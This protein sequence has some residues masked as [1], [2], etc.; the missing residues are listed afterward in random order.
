VAALHASSFTFHVS[1]FLLPPSSFSSVMFGFKEWALICEALGRG[2]QS[3]ILRKGGIA[4]GRAGFRFAHSEFWL[5][6]TLF[7]EQTAKLKVPA[8][9]LLPASREDRMIEV[10]YAARVEW[11]AELADWDKVQALAPFHLWQEAEIEK[12]FQQDAELKVSLAF[13]RVLR[14]REPFVFP[15]L[16]RYGGCRSWVELP[17]TPA[18]LQLDAVLDDPTHR[19]R[20][21]AIRAAIG[22]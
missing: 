18:T 15:N 21:K 16:P 1:S 14:A 5:F 10:H 20:E 2:E 11:T 9:T 17:N 19:E 7:H 6:P 12:R 3:L 8:A 22:R 4:E 13:V